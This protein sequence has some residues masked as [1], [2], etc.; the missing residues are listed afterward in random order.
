MSE[1]PQK[2]LPFIYQFAAG[3]VAGVSEVCTFP[4]TQF[5]LDSLGRVGVL[6]DLLRQWLMRDFPARADSDHVRPS[7]L[8]PG[9]MTTCIA[10]TILGIT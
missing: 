8:F 10:D 7:A 4:R 2:P 1:T 9:R 3:A 5:Q 6:R